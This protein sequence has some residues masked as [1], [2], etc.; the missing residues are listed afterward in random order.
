MSS[1]FR[2]D[3]SRFSIDEEPDYTCPMIDTVLE[4]IDCARTRLSGV[5]PE[6][7]DRDSIESDLDSAE[8]T[9][10]RLDDQL[11]AIRSHVERIRAWGTAWRDAALT[12][13]AQV[14]ESSTRIDELETSVRLLNNEPE[15]AA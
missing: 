4:H 2:T 6:T 8:S 5:C 14:D 3:E 13:E 10:G 12:L 7:D 9:L 11:E 15:A 1:F